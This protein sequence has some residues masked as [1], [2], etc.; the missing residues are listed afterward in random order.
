[1]DL[2]RD[3]DR[4][5]I[6][7]SIL[8]VGVVA[9]SVSAILIRYADGASG[10]A[11]SFWRSAAGSLV[12]LPFTIRRLRALDAR[13]LLLPAVA[14][15]CLAA[16]FASWITSVNMTTIAASVL[17]VSTTPIFV[18]LAARWLFGESMRS[19]GWLGIVLAL[20]GTALI[21]GLDFQGSSAMGNLLALIG[22][23]TVAGYALAGQRSRQR[24]GILEYAVVTYGVSA[25]VLLVWCVVG[26][27]GLTGYP[28]QTWWAIVGLIVG[29]Q[30]LGHT[31]INFALRDIDATRVSMA[32]M[33]E[34]IIAISLA[35]LLF[36]EIPS[37]M[38]YPGGVA[39]LIGIYLVSVARQSPVIISE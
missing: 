8:A 27:I 30:L 31:L 14:G 34:P 2:A 4:I 29:P 24:L 3:Q 28:A 39:I 32:I 19:W 9:A 6:P 25:A 35:Y 5:W 15:V 22:G 12:L 1:M 7:W 38:A 18:A 33:A 26:N 16:H 20:G 37:T 36:T 11:L 13:D 10:V 17:L 21:A 23:I